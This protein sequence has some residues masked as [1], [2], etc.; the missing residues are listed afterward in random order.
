MITNRDCSTRITIR[1]E[2]RS[3]LRVRSMIR[4]MR[5][6]ILIV[7]AAQTR[8]GQG[9]KGK[10]HNRDGGLRSRERRFES[11]WGRLIEHY[12]ESSPAR[13]IGSDLREHGR[14]VTAASHNRPGRSASR[15]QAWSESLPGNG[16]RAEAAAH[17]R[18]KEPLRAFLAGGTEAGCAVAVGSPASIVR[19]SCVLVWML[20]L[21]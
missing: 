19:A 10:S 11:C 5:G 14:A 16:L 2:R 8:C 13:G 12:Y 15:P 17:P 4:N 6:T 20:S 1:W 9:P 3:R 21:R 7:I 18:D